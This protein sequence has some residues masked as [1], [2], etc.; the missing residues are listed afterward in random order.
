MASYKNIAFGFLLLSLTLF[1]YAG[2]VE[3]EVFKSSVLK[4]SLI[5]I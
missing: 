5:H 3:R 4:L 1:S 2:T